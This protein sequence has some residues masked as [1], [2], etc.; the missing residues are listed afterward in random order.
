MKKKVNIHW[1]RRDLRLEDNTALQQA[2]NGDLPVQC[3]FVFDPEIIADLPPNDA[4]ISFIH[5]TLQS[6]DRRLRQQGSSLWVL[7]ADVASAMEEIL[8]VYDVQTVFANEDYEPYAI[9]RDQTV[10]ELLRRS[11]ADL[12]L[13]QDHVLFAKDAILKAD[14]DPYTVFTPYKI[15]WLERLDHWN[16][17]KEMDAFHFNESNHEAVSLRQLGFIPSSIQ[18]PPVNKESISEYAINRDVLA[19][20]TSRLGPHL[21]FGTVSVRQAVEWGKNTPSYLNELIWREFFIQIMYHFPSSMIHNFKRQFDSVQWRND[22]EEFQRW[23]EGRTGIPLV[24]A[25]MHQLNTTGYMHNRVRMVVA[26]FLCKNLLIDW[27]WGEAYFAEKLLDYEMASNVGNWQW[28]AGTGCD[29]A[30]YFRVFNP[31]RQQE[32]FDPHGEYVNRWLGNSAF[33]QPLCDLKESR[34]RAIEEYSKRK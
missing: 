29:A 24:D 18:V 7:H 3:V 5:T 17:P 25:G 23:C 1:F 10:G 28:A 15:K 4:R 12:K 32:R 22:P 14:G 31:I 27:R 30:P 16:A 33:I 26:G 20:E 9:Q 2:C 6:I 19:K 8:R 21:R 11:G 34:K 13:F